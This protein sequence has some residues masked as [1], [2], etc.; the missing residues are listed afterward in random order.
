MPYRRLPNTDKA[1]ARAIK[2]LLEEQEVYREFSE[3][4]LPFALYYQCRNFL[5]EYEKKISEYLQS[6]Q[7]QTSTSKKVQQNTRK[8]RLY[9]SHFIQ[10]LNLSVIR[11]DIKKDKKILYGLNEDDFSVPDLSSDNALLKWGQNIIN[12]EAERLKSGGAALYNPSIQQVI[13]FFDLFKEHALKQRKFQNNTQNSLSAVSAMREQG[14]E[15][16]LKLWDIIEA[17]F[18]GEPPYKRKK[19]CERYGVIYYYRRGEETLTEADDENYLHRKEAKEKAERDQLK[20]W[21][22]EQ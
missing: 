21:Q 22:E 5:Q 15:L 9:V 1:R 2:C 17:H 4:E 20:L 3:S 14:D 18:A 13:V 12:G 6:L 10:V 7:T 8:A 19:D 16:V 11:G